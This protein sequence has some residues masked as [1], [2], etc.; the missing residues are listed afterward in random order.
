MKQKIDKMDEKLDDTNRK[1][2]QKSQKSNEMN[3]KM[4]TKEWREIIK[5]LQQ[6]KYM[7]ITELHGI[8]Q[9]FGVREEQVEKIVKKKPPK[10]E[11]PKQRRSKRLLENQERGLRSR[12]KKLP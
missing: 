8:F 11:I 2:D 3:Q 6:T 7:M 12:G 9:T 4:R 5:E 1:N 10:S